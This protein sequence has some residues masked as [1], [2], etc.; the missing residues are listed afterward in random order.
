MSE[1]TEEMNDAIDEMRA[2][3][4]ADDLAQWDAIQEWK[5]AQ[6]RPIRPRVI[7][8][9]IRSYLLAPLAKAVSLARKVPGGA[10]VTGAVASGILRLGRARDISRRVFDQP[11]ANRQGFPPGWV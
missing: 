11:R 5:A 10:A 6:I 9:R 8:Q 4:S 7:S 1:S 2:R 3:M